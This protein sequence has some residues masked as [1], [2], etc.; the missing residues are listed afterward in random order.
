MYYVY[1][2]IIIYNKSKECHVATIRL[3]I[4]MC[5]VYQY[6]F[7]HRTVNSPWPTWA[8]VMH[9]DEIAFVFGDPFR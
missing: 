6:H 7:L 8:G 5:S 3:K 4:I 1:S 9:G 2:C